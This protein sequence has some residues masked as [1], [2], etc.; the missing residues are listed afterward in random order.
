MKLFNTQKLIILA[1]FLVV[2]LFT[3]QACDTTSTDDHDEHAD[4]V[5]FVIEQNNAEVLRFENNQANWNPDGAWDDYYR[6]GINAVVISPDVIQLSE[7]NPRGMTPSVTLRWIDADG[8]VFDLPNDENGEYSL[9]WE[10]E[11]ANTAGDTCSAEAREN[12]EQLDTIRPANLEQHGSGSDGLWGFHFR[13]DHAGQDRL[14]FSLMHNDH[15]DFTSRWIDVVVANDE[16]PLIDA[17][18]IYMHQRDKCRVDR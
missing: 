8:D 15:A 7:D 14:R 13:A 18:G 16:H 17:N 3:I 12:V 4:A 1:T 5:G 10:W 6:D 9:T 11:K 2:T